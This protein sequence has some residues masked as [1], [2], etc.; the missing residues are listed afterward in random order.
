M[1]CGSCLSERQSESEPPPEQEPSF[2]TPSLRL[3]LLRMRTELKA[4]LH[5]GLDELYASVAL[6]VGAC[7]YRV[8]MRESPVAK[9]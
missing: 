7:A 9:Q 1:H 5:A 4:P 8:A 3:G 2:E 6:P